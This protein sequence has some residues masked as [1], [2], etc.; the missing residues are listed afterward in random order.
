MVT[1]SAPNSTAPQGQVVRQDPAAGSKVAKGSVVTIFVSG[2]GTKVPGVVGEPSQAE[3]TAAAQNDGFT[4]NTQTGR[5]RLTPGTVFQTE[6]E[7]GHGAGAGFHG[8]HLRCRQPAA[9]DDARR[10]HHRPRPSQPS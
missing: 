6:P 2:G 4:V 1:K 10:P 9:A 5:G 3:A 8:D 7:R